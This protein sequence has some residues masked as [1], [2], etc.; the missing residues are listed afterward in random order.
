V[1]WQQS[2]HVAGLDARLA[3][4]NLDLIFKVALYPQSLSYS[5]V[6]FN[7]YEAS[8]SGSDG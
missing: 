7:I 8:D 2:C 4:K 5:V 3:G 1:S 6:K